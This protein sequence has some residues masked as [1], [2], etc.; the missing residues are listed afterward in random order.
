[1][2][3]IKKEDGGGEKEG[4]S[5]LVRAGVVSECAKVCV[6]LRVRARARKQKRLLALPTPQLARTV[7][8][9]Q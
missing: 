7:Q 5:Q 2:L 8:E 6:L 1:M 9:Q 4:G 3:Q